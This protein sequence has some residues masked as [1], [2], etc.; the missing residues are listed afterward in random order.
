MVLFPFGGNYSYQ[1]DGIP[2]IFA[3]SRFMFNLQMKDL[4]LKTEKIVCYIPAFNAERLIEG[5]IQ[6]IP[7]D[8][9]DGID[10]FLV[11][12]DGS[13]DETFR[14]CSDLSR[15]FSKIR[16]LRHEKNRG[17]GAAQKTAFEWILENGGD[18]GVMLHSDGQ[19]PPEYLLPML[20]PFSEGADV[21]GG[22]RILYGD[23]RD[24]GMSLT[25]FYGTL[26]LNGLENLVFRQK[27]TSYHS[28]YKAYSREAIQ[29]IPFLEYSDTFNFD[30]EM[31]VGAIRNELEIAEV[32]IPTIHGEG[33]SSLK[34]VPYGLSVL[35][36]VIRYIFGKI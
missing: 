20:K 32:P 22:S 18:I 16:I 31:L 29:R 2:C 10:T 19:Y 21:V 4:I 23:M 35:R 14:V 8:A 26:F 15:Q 33:F 24:G 11:I 9:R 30:S 36:T 27:L 28:G 3:C 12:D 13:T 1:R 25:R 7:E 17:Y 6:S 34:P 5:V